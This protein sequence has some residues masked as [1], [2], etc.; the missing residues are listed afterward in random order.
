MEGNPDTSTQPPLPLER[1]FYAT[2]NFPKVAIPIMEQTGAVARGT[3]VLK[4]TMAPVMEAARYVW[5]CVWVDALLLMVTCVLWHAGPCAQCH[6]RMCWTSLP[7]SRYVAWGRHDMFVSMSAT[8]TVCA[9]A[10]CLVIITTGCT[11]QE[12]V[13]WRSIHRRAHGHVCM[14][15]SCRHASPPPSHP[16]PL[17]LLYNVCLRYGFPED[18]EYTFALDINGQ[19]TNW[20]LG[21]MMERIGGLTVAQ[22]GAGTGGKAEL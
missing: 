14:R 5:V 12:A 9:R 1:R 10:G 3:K 17:L 21:S 2:D 8:L 7:K 19:D 18:Y 22:I 15:V 11:S 4:S 16:S 13:L 6:S 20:P